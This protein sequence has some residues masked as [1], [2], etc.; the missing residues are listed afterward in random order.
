V[1]IPGVSIPGVS[2]PS[3]VR[4]ALPVTGGDVL[5]LVLV[6]LGAIAAGGGMTVL[7]RRRLT[8]A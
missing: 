5:I 4:G 2:V 7:G 1:S 3:S 8:R 6:A